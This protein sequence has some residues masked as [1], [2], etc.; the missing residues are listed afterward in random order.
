MSH[1]LIVEDEARIASFL[2]KGLRANGFATTIAGNG[3]SGLELAA[4]GEFDLV[5]LDVGLPGRDGFS[6]LSELRRRRIGVPVIVL[7]ARAGIE[8]TVAGLEGG[9]DDYL[10]KPFRFEELL[11]RV[12]LRRRPGARHQRAA[13]RRRFAG[14][15]NPDHRPRRP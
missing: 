1:V 13:R 3:H 8:D 4:S 12:R 10:A 2:D 14:P 11:A 6:V 9:A 7:T 15:A 5:L